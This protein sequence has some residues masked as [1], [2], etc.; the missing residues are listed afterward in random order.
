MEA[1][2]I[3]GTRRGHENVEKRE[4]ERERARERGDRRV[5]LVLEK[6]DRKWVKKK[7]SSNDG[8]T[9]VVVGPIGMLLGSRNKGRSL[10]GIE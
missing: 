10:L 4:R 9:N 8:I 5:S 3:E 6:T 2:R 7:T 1:L